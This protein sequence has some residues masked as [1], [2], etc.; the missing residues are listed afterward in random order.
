[1]VNDKLKNKKLKNRSVF[2]TDWLGNCKT[3]EKWNW[4]SC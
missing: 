4:C 2:V 1:M 3:F